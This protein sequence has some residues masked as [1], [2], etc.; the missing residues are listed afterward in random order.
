MYICILPSPSTS[1]SI[2]VT[3]I[4]VLLMLDAPFRERRKGKGGKTIVPNIT[5]HHCA[6]IVDI[7]SWSCEKVE[8]ATIS[9]LEILAKIVEYALRFLWGKLN[10]LLKF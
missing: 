2:Q 4:F 1:D 10:F 9:I 5:R 7:W 8:F 3:F 6:I